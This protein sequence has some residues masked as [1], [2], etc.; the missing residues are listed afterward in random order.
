MRALLALALAACGAMPPAPTGGDA[1]LPPPSDG[2]APVQDGGAFAGDGGGSAADGGAF[3]GGALP[4]DGGGAFAPDA[5]PPPAGPYPH[6]GWLSPEAPNGRVLG[7]DLSQVD[8]DAL[9]HADGTA[10]LYAVGGGPD[11]WHSDREPLVLV[12]GIQGVP[13]DLQSMVDRFWSG[14]YQLYVLCYNDYNRRTSLNGLDLAAEM[15]ALEPRLTGNGRRVTFAAHSLG[16]IVVRQALNELSL[17]DTGGIELF[18]RIRL[19][20]LDNPWHG[21]D[22]P[23]D[24]PLMDIARPFM[25]DGLEDMRALSGMFQGDPTSGDPALRAGLLN[26]PL[27]STVD[28]V[29]VFAQA[30]D[31]VLDYTEGVVA[32]LP[33]KMAAL[34]AQGTP[35]DGEPKLVNFWKAIRS[36]RAYAALDADLRALGAS[37]DAA[38]VRE[39]LL[40]HYPRFPGD[41]TGVLAEHPG[42]RSLLDFLAEELSR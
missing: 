11:G 35:V 8:E 21:Y 16:G 14:R 12:H 36:A 30:G 42:E 6:N 28:I 20:G 40:R 29:P 2:G 31:L 34:Y 17:G 3:D 13:A 18:G 4:P 26:V 24:G 15:R 25:P 5:G 1:G 32:E 22:G 19:Y 39:A 10:A 7:Y 9:L 41:H 27:P 33:W 38:A 37:V 23:A